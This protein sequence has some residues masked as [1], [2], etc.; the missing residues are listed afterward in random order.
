MNNMIEKCIA[1]FNLLPTSQSH[2]WL[3]AADY[4]EESDLDITAE[5]FRNNIFNLELTASDF[6]AHGSSCGY[7]W[8]NNIGCGEAFLTDAFDYSNIGN[9]HGDCR[10]N[11]EGDGGGSGFA[12][13]KGQGNAYG[14]SDGFGE[15]YNEDYEYQP[16]PISLFNRHQII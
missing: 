5:A 15:D 13:G 14:E 8:G 10:G 9:G 3:I 2:H 11:G 4:L 1:L 16:F 7:G 6:Y 12:N